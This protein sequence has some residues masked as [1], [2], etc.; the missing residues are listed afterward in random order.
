MN[1][2]LALLAVAVFQAPQRVATNQ[3]PTASTSADSARDLSRAHGAQNA[4]ERSRRAQLPIAYGSSGRC[5]VRLG[6][7]CWWYDE[8]TPKFAPEADIVGVRRSELIAELDALSMRYPGDDWLAG[9]RVYYRIDGKMLASAETAATG[10][11]AAAWWC[12][13]LVGYASHALGNVVR[14]DSAFGAA[15]LAMRAPD[16]CAWRSPIITANSPFSSTK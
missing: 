11:R 16:A 6:R 7:Y 5:E 2:P 4:F 14:A 10:C 8:H 13:A 12:S 9:M 3:K 1:M 15:I